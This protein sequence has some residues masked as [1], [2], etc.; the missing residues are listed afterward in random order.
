MQMQTK[1]QRSA[2]CSIFLKVASIAASPVTTS[3]YGEGEYW[4][5]RYGGWAPDPYDWLF[6][7][8]ANLTK[9]QMMKQSVSVLQDLH[10]LIAAFVN[11]QVIVVQHV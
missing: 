1:S 9:L 8:K 4:D 2:L 5:E 7:F 3:R 11:K 10:E 6:E